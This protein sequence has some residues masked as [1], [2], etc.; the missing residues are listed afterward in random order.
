MSPEEK[1]AV[2]RNYVLR[3][4]ARCGIISLGCAARPELSCEAFGEF[5]NLVE[6]QLMLTEEGFGAWRELEHSPALDGA[7]RYVTERYDAL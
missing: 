5:Y 2:V 7:Y 1:L 4:R 6:R 3:M